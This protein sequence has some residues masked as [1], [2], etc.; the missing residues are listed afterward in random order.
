VGQG[1]PHVQVSASISLLN[2]S[3]SLPAL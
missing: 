3:T 1:S 2:F